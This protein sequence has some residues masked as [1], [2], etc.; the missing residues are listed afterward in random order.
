MH[1]DL[2]KHF[3]RISALLVCPIA[4]HF[5][6]HLWSSLLKE[7]KSVQL[8]LWPQ[9]TKP[10]DKSL[11]EAA[12]YMRTTLKSIRD[13]EIALQKRA[14]KRAA[15]GATFDSNKPKGVRIFV[16]STFP[17][18]QEECVKVAK[19]CYDFNSDKLDDAKVRETLTTKG[20]MK[21]KRCMPFVQNFKVP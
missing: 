6:E 4:P 21:D 11:L 15:A 12:E 13:A 18:W 19:D 7:P 20:L 2:I 1:V 14:G 17:E 5:A 16:A 3:I 9:P 10:V 8:A